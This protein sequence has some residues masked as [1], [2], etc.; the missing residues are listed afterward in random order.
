M[1]VHKV[2]KGLDLPITGAPAQSVRDAAPVSRVAILPRDY[3]GMK[4]KMLVQPGDKVSLG[5][6][7]FEDRKNPGVVFV[8]PGT[9]TVAAVN[10]GDRRALLSVV[11]E[12]GEDGAEKA[13]ESFGPHADR[14][15]EGVRALLLESGL[16]TALRTRPFGRVPA[17]DATPSSI[18]VTAID[19]HPLAPQPEVVLAGREEDFQRGLAVLGRLTPGPVYL[20]RAQGSRLDPGKSG[21]RVEEFTGRHPAGTVGYHIHVLDPVNRDKLVFHVG[22]QDTARIGRLFASGRLD[23]SCVISVAGPLV[24]R[25]R[26]LRT[27]LG[28]STN[29]LVE[30]GLLPSEEEPRIISGSV[31]H[32][33][34]A[35]GPIEGFLGRYHNQISVIAEGR[36]RE[37]LGWMRPG[38]RK[39]SFIPTFISALLPRKLF[40]FDTN[41]NGS[42]RAM[43]PIGLYERV[44][45]MDLM[46]THLLRA[47]AVGDV[48]WAEELGALELDEEDLALC[49]FVCPGKFDYG[50]ALR[51][52][53]TTLAQEG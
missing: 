50:P 42:R 25:P 24:K 16:W 32:G 34:R 38:A 1:A 15:A 30:G 5:Q 44:M 53:L 13:M 3:V 33:Y 41:T 37:L 22:Y 17:P 23:T 20:C 47:L 9:G 7:L 31:L 19:T 39:F 26:L 43:V 45:P 18:F 51:R 49:T 2:K 10:R 48:E 14:N 35:S 29:E 4:P 21:A 6:P 46:P 11:I 28:A 12:L 40:D 8:A 27:R 36:R 52:V